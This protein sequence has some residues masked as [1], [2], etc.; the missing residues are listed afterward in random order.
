MSSQRSEVQS[1]FPSR[2][3]GIPAPAQL[4]SAGVVDEING[5]IEED[6]E[7]IAAE[8]A[9]EPEEALRHR[10]KQ[11]D[12]YDRFTL[13]RVTSE[14]KRREEW[15]EPA[16][17]WFHPV[18]EADP[19]GF[20]RPF[21]SATYPG[22][23]AAIRKSAELL[24][25][26]VS[27]GEELMVSTYCLRVLVRP[28]TLYKGF[29][30][31][32]SKTGERCGTCVWYPR[33]D[34][35]KIDGATLFCSLN[36]PTVPE[37]VMRLREPDFRFDPGEYHRK[38]LV[39]RYPDNLFHGVLKGLHKHPREE[40]RVPGAKDFIQPREDDFVKDLMVVTLSESSTAEE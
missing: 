26:N 27:A 6:F 8:L 14:R 21:G 30:H 24:A 12:N 36:D 17:G 35:G 37:R 7:R 3:G 19:S 16:E 32:D 15:A 25:E 28:G 39:M 29:K 4:L 33:V 40:G 10:L 18:R 1:A 9:A 13:G 23:W 22:L 20:P 11:Y 31:R 34:A 2:P 5:R 38:L